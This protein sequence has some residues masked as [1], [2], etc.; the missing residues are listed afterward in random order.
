MSKQS[1]VPTWPLALALMMFLSGCA[2]TG[3]GGLGGGLSSLSFLNSYDAVLRDFK[4]GRIM[5]AR[6]KA[7]AFPKDHKDYPRVRQLLKSRIDP[8]RVRLLRQY[9]RLAEREE[10]RGNWHKAASM[11]AQAAAFSSQP[12]SLLARAEAMRLRMRQARLDALIRERRRED[13][14]LLSWRAAYAP[15]K[16]VSA[17]DPV[18]LRKR[19]QY[20]ELIE[21]RADM[22][23]KEARRYLRRDMPE[24]AFVEIESYLRLEPDSANGRELMAEIRKAMPKGLKIPA[25]A[26]ESKA[27]GSK[28]KPRKR[29]KPVRKVT[30]SQIR[31][32]LHAGKLL[33]AK[34]YALVYRREGGKGAA[35]MLKQVNK[36]IV[37]RA[38]DRYMKGRLAFR[39]EQL[40]RAIEYWREAVRLM[41]GKREY[42]QALDR[43]RQLKERL[44]LLR[45][46]SA[47]PADP[48][49]GKGKGGAQGKAK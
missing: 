15:P 19:E 21:E 7:L 34:R 33:E 2:S 11:Y 6:K 43:A 10:K 39:K 48:Y 17:E 41:P 44:D 12:A 37:A 23:W 20:Q 8:A 4:A 40:D 30:A 9:R 42:A 46:S 27:R 25:F 38:E 22:A 24:I 1:K 47:Q 3:S 29:A 18:F 49:A 45:K 31:K 36:A 35:N 14:E 5:E 16:G 32:L 26:P 28:A 13:R